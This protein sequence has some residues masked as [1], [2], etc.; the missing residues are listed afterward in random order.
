MSGGRLMITV[1]MGIASSIA[2]LVTFLSVGIPVT[3]NLVLLIIAAII[4]SAGITLLLGRLFLADASGNKT[5][6]SVEYA[7]IGRNAAPA[8]ELITR[9]AGDITSVKSGIEKTT[10]CATGLRELLKVRDQ[11]PGGIVKL[12]SYINKF[13]QL[14]GELKSLVNNIRLIEKLA[15]DINGMGQKE[16]AMNNQ[17]KGRIIAN[18][19]V[20]KSMAEK[21]DSL[22]VKSGSITNIINSIQSI[23][24][25]TNLLALNAAIEAAR[26]GEAG[27]GFAVV[28]QEI[29]K[30]AEQTATATKEIGRIV[31]E[32]QGEVKAVNENM[33]V[34]SQVS[35]QVDFEIEDP[36]KVLGAFAEKLESAVRDLA[37]EIGRSFDA[38][39]PAG[40][41]AY[42]DNFQASTI[43]PLVKKFAQATD[44]VIEVYFSL[45]PELTPFLNADDLMY[46][47]DYSNADRTGYIQQDL[48]AKKECVRDNPYFAWYFNPV[49]KK[50]GVWSKVYFDSY[51]NTELI[52][53]TYAIFEGGSLIGVAGMDIDFNDFRKNMN[54]LVVKN[55]AEEVRV[56]STTIDKIAN[57]QQSIIACLQGEAES[58][59]KPL[60]TD[61]LLLLIDNQLSGLKVVDNLVSQLHDSAK[62][63]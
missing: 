14:G 58:S 11:Q 32:I 22:S 42:F 49:D 56:L 4:I 10:Q 26:A 43:N 41:K 54:S 9:I 28:A 23:A 17:L 35:S 24:K 44:G 12:D 45:N 6:E 25:Q 36:R 57:D 52:S 50:A 33:A 20:V 48:L 13:S 55:V 47:S 40:D 8:N 30:L 53:Y 63:M 5:G 7:M 46:G 51:V 19:D 38:Q 31:L 1:V 59:K 16:I 60:N 15:G 62:V 27:R 3:T 37:S 2:L 29:G 21:V 34:A 39:R 61:N 18:A